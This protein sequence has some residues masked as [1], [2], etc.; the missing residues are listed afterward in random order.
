MES[1]Q[2]EYQKDL[3]SF[4]S[5]FEKQFAKNSRNSAS[6][7]PMQNISPFSLTFAGSDNCDV[8]DTEEK[9]SHVDE[10][11]KSSRNKPEKT[12]KPVQSEYKRLYRSI[13][14]KCHPD[15]TSNDPS[16]SQQNK[17]LFIYVLDIAMNAYKKNMKDELVYAAA[18]VD[19]YPTKVST[20]ACLAFL[21]NMYLSSTQKIEEYQ[22][23][24]SWAW[25]VNW[26]TVEIRYKIIS[27]MCKRSGFPL[28][29]KS[30][31]IK[32]LVEY[33]AN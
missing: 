32:F 24:L 3:E 1:L 21:N 23:S 6:S 5:A 27:A 22:D 7:E 9:T 2:K 10:E 19:I 29:P 30:D 31:V 15:R 8:D 20:K 17:A 14:Q 28:P 4:F 16:I 25:G 13:M 12:K 18:L 33:E 26:D 11:N